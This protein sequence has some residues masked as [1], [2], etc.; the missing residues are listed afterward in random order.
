MKAVVKKVRKLEHPSSASG[1]EY[2]N[3]LY[4]VIGDDANALFILYPAD[5]SVQKTIP[6]VR[7]ELVQERI[8]KKQ[9][10][11]FECMSFVYVQEVPH[12]LIMGSGSKPQ[13]QVAYLYNLV[14]QTMETLDYTDFYQKLEKDTSFTL[15]AELNVE[16]ATSTHEHIYLFQRGNNASKNT[17]LRFSVQD[18][19][20]PND[21]RIFTADLPNI[22]KGKAGF[23]GA[24]YVL[25]WNALLFT[26]SVELTKDAYNDG[27]VLGSFVGII[28]QNQVKECEIITYPDGRSYIAKVE[29]ISV[30][31]VL[32][33][34]SLVAVAV[35]DSDGK[36]SEMIEIEITR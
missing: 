17:F 36:A 8:P 35:T 29:S 21:Y 18:I 25:E 3:G 5:L 24:C 13:R 22:E 4:Y 11:D 26:A 20:K 1:I 10:S 9:K 12:I 34:R 2:I 30:E 16:A 32:N 19:L 31:K 6:F 14:T 7:G 33:P 15:G 23:S 27:R 28:E